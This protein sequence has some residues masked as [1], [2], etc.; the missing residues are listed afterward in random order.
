VN[1]L[2]LGGC[3]FIGSHLADALIG[4]EDTITIF[5]HSTVDRKN[6]QHL[7]EHIRI[8]EGDSY[9]ERDIGRAVQGADVVVHLIGATLP[10]SSLKNPIYDAETNII[11]SLK[12]LNACIET[13]V[14]KVVFVSSGGTVYGI[15]Q[16]NPIP[17]SHPLNPIAPYGISKMIIEKY[18]GMYHYHY[19]LDYTVLR[20]SNPFGARQNPQKGQGVI[21]SWMHR[22]AHG[23]AI[24]IWGDGSVVRDY[25]YIKDAVEAIKLAT[26]KETSKKA[27]MNVGSGIGYSLSELHGLLEKVIGRSIPI[28]YRDAQKVDVPV[29]VLDV[30]LI[31]RVLGWRARTSVEQGM[32]M[33]W[34][35][36]GKAK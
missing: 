2:I 23:E 28:S 36:L 31:A 8:I 4:G 14:R 33:T 6:I 17:E 25:V 30:S 5:D 29:N 32:R 20:L 22:I 12:L 24:E 19:G 11:G 16:A 35:T 1:I 7:Q 34:K 3:G 27:I 18:L 13:K 10:S 9:N 21:A 15:P 26:L